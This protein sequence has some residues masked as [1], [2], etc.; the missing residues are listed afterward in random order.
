MEDVIHV[1]DNLA[2][3]FKVADISPDEFDPIEE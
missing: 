3:E 2:A 1:F